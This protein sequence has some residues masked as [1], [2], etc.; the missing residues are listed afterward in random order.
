MFVAVSREKWYGLV[1]LYL[2]KWRMRASERKRV[3][4]GN[5]HSPITS[6]ARKTENTD[7]LVLKISL[8]SE[9]MI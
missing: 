4:M 6:L 1:P 8:C 2:R 3:I 5:G 9:E 7:I